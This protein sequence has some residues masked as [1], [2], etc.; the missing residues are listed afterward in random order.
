MPVMTVSIARLRRLTLELE[1]LLE[2]KLGELDDICAPAA[3]VLA[4]R[5]Q[6]EG[7][8]PRVETGLYRDS[9]SGHLEP[10]AFVRLDGLILDPTRGQFDEGP[11]VSRLGPRYLPDEEDWGA[12]LAPPSHPAYDDARRFIASWWCSIDCGQDRRAAML[13]V[14]DVFERR[15]IPDVGEDLQG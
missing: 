3:V 12:G 4:V 13:D 15:E 9:G 2:E 14:L 1:T 10:H 7:L 5:L 6:E 8:Q 11:R